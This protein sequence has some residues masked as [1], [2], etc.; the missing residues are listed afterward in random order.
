MN[1]TPLP[2][3]LFDLTATVARLQ[4]DAILAARQD[5]TEH[6]M[7]QVHEA[8]LDFDRAIQHANPMQPEGRAR[9]AQLE[10]RCA[11]FAEMWEKL[12]EQAR[13]KAGAL[14]GD[15]K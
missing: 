3:R 10:E 6:S 4:R 13:D 2:V 7:H 12:Q 5:R 14:K 9:L 1:H 15:G 8:I 11:A